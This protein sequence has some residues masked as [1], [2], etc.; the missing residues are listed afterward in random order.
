ME[1]AR[2]ARLKNPRVMQQLVE[3]W[4][5]QETWHEKLPDAIKLNDKVSPD[6]AVRVV[7]ERTEL[8]V[9]E[10]VVERSRGVQQQWQQ[11]FPDIAR[12][13][14]GLNPESVDLAKPQIL[15]RANEAAALNSAENIVE[16]APRAPG[17]SRTIGAA[18]GLGVAASAYD[19]IDTGQRV[20]TLLAQDN[21]LAAQSQ[22][23][24]YAARGVGGWVGGAA[25]GLAVGWETGPGVIAFVAVGAVSG[26]YVGEQAAQWWDDR[27]IYNQTDRDGV[28]WNYNGQQWLRQEAADLHDDGVNRPA[29]QSFSALPDKAQELT[30]M[31]SNTATA[32]AMGKLEPPRDPY[33]LP[34]SD[35]DAASLRRADWQ[36]NPQSGE[37]DR[38]VVV[39]YEQRGVPMTRPEAASPERAAEL[40][41]ASEQVIR[42]NIANG[43]AP[44]AARYELAYHSNGWDRFGA[45][46]TA[47]QTALTDNTL[48]ASDAK[49]YRR[50]GSGQWQREGAPGETLAQGNLQQEL[51]RTSAALQPQLA[52]HQQQV[53]TIPQWQPPTR[54]QLDRTNLVSTYAASGVAP[55]PE[56]LA[57]ALE[58]VQR[59]REAQGVDAA[60]TSLNLQPNAH[61]GFDVNSPI[62]HLRRDGDGVVRIAAVTSREE[63]ALAMV[64]LRSQPALVPDTPE[65]RIAALSPQQRQAHEQALREANRQGLSHDQ[66]QQ[67]TQHAAAVAASPDAPRA[68]P[69]PT[70]TPPTRTQDFSAMPSDARPGVERAFTAAPQMVAAASPVQLSPESAEPKSEADTQVETAQPG[71]FRGA[72]PPHIPSE[73]TVPAPVAAIPPAAAGAQTREDTLRPDSQGQEVEL[74]QYRLHRVGYRG[75][76]GEP[77]P[78]TGRYD[79]ATEHAVRQFQRDQGIADTGVVDPATQ[80]AISAAQHAR[81]ESSKAPRHETP[82]APPSAALS[83]PE[84]EPRLQPAADDSAS[85][86]ARDPRRPAAESSPQ[87]PWP[88][89]VPAADA[90]DRNEPPLTARI[91]EPEQHAD[92]PV[93]SRPVS[94]LTASRDDED[95]MREPAR[96]S[97]RLTSEPLADLSQLTPKDQAMFAKIRNG[98]PSNVSDETVAHAMLEAK[99]NGIPDADRTGQVG[100]VD[101][102]LWVGGVTP[103]FHANV[104]ASGPAPQM[105]DTLR[106]VQMFN[107]QRDRQQAQEM[108]QQQRQQEEQSN[109][110]RMSH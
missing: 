63:I 11:S 101:G 82:A 18:V 108:A 41:R 19:A 49:Q 107:E 50:D 99:R 13:G 59:T 37:W 86:S 94:S 44:I 35:G 88:A 60:T 23:S 67:V 20:G 106:E 51:D 96:K 103:G 77:L 97:P 12:T 90:R 74:L 21:P 109:S 79:A 100:V 76:D 15:S 95:H 29:K 69:M 83:N 84:H 43:P 48:I 9:Q 70:D 55:N 92:T 31:A 87:V 7:Q 104:S 61:G 71:Q 52:Q 4:Q 53:A 93:P 30:F 8:K 28:A 62:E 80:Q 64:D 16:H 5:Q 14:I 17:V 3:G 85:H 56:Q 58:A 10:G 45:V 98:A 66:V 65:L 78:Q 26:S 91:R 25:T 68:E 73:P 89:T 54:E 22:L 1:E 40:D 24:H 38:N 110:M 75:A 33:S 105:Q 102:K 72:A 32:L 2:E 42:D 34:A 46:P 27:K 81:I 36:R 47:V 39:G 57:A 6:T